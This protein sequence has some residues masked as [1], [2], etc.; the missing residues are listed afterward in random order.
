MCVSEH[1]NTTI[2]QT[3]FIISSRRHRA[4]RKLSA[5]YLVHFTPLRIETRSIGLWCVEG[6]GTDTSDLGLDP[7]ALHPAELFHS[8]SHL[9][10]RLVRVPGLLVTRNPQRRVARG[11]PCRLIVDRLIA[12]VTL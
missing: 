4:Q 8:G 1:I 5:P 10:S 11:I 12:L 2:S 9:Q 6:V 3:P 7:A